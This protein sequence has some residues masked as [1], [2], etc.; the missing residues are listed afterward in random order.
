MSHQTF[1]GGVGNSY[2]NAGEYATLVGPPPRFL[3]SKGKECSITKMRHKHSLEAKFGYFKT[4]GAQYDLSYIFRN[5]YNMNLKK[6]RLHKQHT[7]ETTRKRT[8]D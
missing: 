3:L 5:K 6:K 7:L 1:F 4:R 8:K 2:S